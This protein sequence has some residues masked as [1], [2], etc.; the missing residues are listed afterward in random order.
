[1]LS[2]G[3]LEDTPF[4]FAK[5]HAEVRA[6][7]QGRHQ[8]TQ[9]SGLKGDA[10]PAASNGNGSSRGSGGDSGDSRRGG[11]N[12][13]SSASSSSSNGGGDKLGDRSYERLSAN[14][15]KQESYSSGDYKHSRREGSSSK[16]V[17]VP[18]PPPAPAVPVQQ[19]Q[20]YWLREGI[21]VKIVSRSIGGSK[22]YLQKGTVLDVYARGQATVRLDD[23]TVLDK[24]GERHVETIVPAVGSMC[25]VLL[26]EYKGQHATLLEKRR[27]DQRV[28]VQL[29]DDLEVVEL[30]M[31]YISA[32]SS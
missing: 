6:E 7:A 5:N 13:S 14:E 17:N 8:L 26:G 2:A 4:I 21:R 25:V 22:A 10:A 29:S 15:S 16:A 3:E 18:P 32:L 11:A 23:R 27:D 28:I 9:Y 31:D 19:Q 20:V 30:D 1:M 24:V 12:S